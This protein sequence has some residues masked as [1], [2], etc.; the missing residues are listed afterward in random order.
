MNWRAGGEG[1]GGGLDKEGGRV[2]GRTGARQGGRAS[3]LSCRHDRREQ[4]A[5]EIWS[6]LSEPGGQDE[7]TEKTILSPKAR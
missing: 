6:L 4:R 5:R 2:G 1:G 3:I 7:R